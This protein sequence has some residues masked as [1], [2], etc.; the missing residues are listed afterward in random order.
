MTLGSCKHVIMTTYPQYY[1]SHKNKIPENSKVAI[2]AQDANDGSRIIT[3]IMGNHEVQLMKSD[4]RAEAVVG[5]ETLDLSRSYQHIENDETIFE[6]ARLPDES[7]NVYSNKY[8]LNIVYDGKR[9]QI[10]VSINIKQ[11]GNIKSITVAQK[12]TK[13][14]NKFV[15]RHP[16]DIAMPY[17]VSPATMTRC[18][19]TIS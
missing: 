2:L 18:L 1:D 14:R 7:I 17:A 3:V 5:R 16:T 13:N 4:N 15:I 8:G 12:H 11:T 6:I 9:V 10:W 19:T